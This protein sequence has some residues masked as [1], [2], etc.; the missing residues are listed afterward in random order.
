MK[1]LLVLLL[2]LTLIPTGLATAQSASA[3]MKTG[4]AARA[5]AETVTAAQLKDYLSFVSS[6][7]MEGR[8]TPSRGLD[9]TALF[10]STLLARWGVQ[11][12]GDSGTYFQK[13][14]LLRTVVKDEG[15]VA[16]IG[17]RTFKY[18][19]SFL[20]QAR[21]GNVSAPL[22][23]VGDGWY[24]KSK[25]IDAYAGL[26]V[27]GKIVVVRG[28]GFPTGL[29]F[30]ELRQMDAKDWADPTHY[31]ERSGAAG[32]IIL[33]DPGTVGAWDRLK[34]YQQNVGNLVV[35]GIPSERDNT[36]SIPVITANPAMAT[37]LFE[38]EAVTAASVFDTTKP[39]APFAF[40]APRKV[41]FTIAAEEKIQWTQN[42]VGVIPGSDPR[43]KNEYVAVGAHYDHIGLSA[44]GVNGDLINNGADDDG[45]GTVSI[46]AFA[47]AVA[48]AKV[49]PRRSILFVWHC[50]E[51]KGLWGSQY[52][53]TH[54]TIPLRQVVTQ[55]NIDMIGRSKPAGDTQPRNKDLSGPDEIYV[56]GSK[57]MSTDLGALSERVNNGYLKLAFNYKYDDPTDPNRYF[58]RSDHFNYAQKGVPIIFYFDGEHVDYHRPSD[59][60]SRIDFNKMERVARTVFMT[61]WE[62]ADSAEKP[63][64]DKELP[65][66]LQRR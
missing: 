28:G 30:T 51:E 16:S 12:A 42:V 26:E 57:M 63:T 47:D 5:T 56:I 61:M 53:T 39:V 19:E 52:F 23:Y 22:V 25:N 43:L 6:D 4:S 9:I 8:D 45:S 46:L 24:V 60:I 21:A 41:S 38:G 50:G 3:T 7:L 40:G 35:E 2:W 65:G 44:Q 10:I 20:A 54:P 34:R 59:E 18:G 58:F 49:K 66:L 48:H 37:A 36:V 55:L 31:A 17:G 32:V 33:A 1:R 15:T 27:K 64:V 29:T 11:P 14:K 13:I 62:I